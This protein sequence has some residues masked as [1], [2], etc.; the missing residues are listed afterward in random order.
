MEISTFD[1]SEHINN[2]TNPFDEKSRLERV[3]LRDS[4]RT[5]LSEKFKPSYLPS[6]LKRN[7]NLAYTDK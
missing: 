2:S 3:I 1:I 5:N 6:A 7:T 4:F